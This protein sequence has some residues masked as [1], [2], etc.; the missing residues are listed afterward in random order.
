MALKV[1]QIETRSWSSRRFTTYPA[2]NMSR[3]QLPGTAKMSI[4]SSVSVSPMRRNGMQARIRRLENK[5]MAFAGACDWE[6]R[7]RER[8]L[9]QLHLWRSLP[10]Y[11]LL[12]ESG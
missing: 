5:K 4:A 3:N 2:K 6:D 9:Y 11:Q 8:A 1:A 7:E 10:P 12:E